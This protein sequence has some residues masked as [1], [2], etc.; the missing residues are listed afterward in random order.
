MLCMRMLSEDD[1]RQASMQQ[2]NCGNSGIIVNQ[3]GGMSSD[4]LSQGNNGNSGV[5]V[6]PLQKIQQISK[7]L[8]N[9]E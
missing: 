4:T 5:V 1:P 6:T 3:N 8:E 2:G 9:P 7:I